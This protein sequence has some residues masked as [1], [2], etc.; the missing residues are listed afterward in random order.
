[1]F[2]QLIAFDGPRSAELVAAAERAGRDRI[3]PL[4]SADSQIRA[5]HRGTYVLRRPDGG[6]LILV[7]SDTV[8]AL[9]RA[10][11]LINDSELLPGEDP[12]LLSDPDRVEVYEVVHALD[13][14]YHELEHRS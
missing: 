13:R 12:A 11:K 5:A 3:T 14:D 6:Q 2:A 4:V 7:L 1:V 8:D 9:E 10:N